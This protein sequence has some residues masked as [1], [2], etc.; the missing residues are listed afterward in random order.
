MASQLTGRSAWPLSEDIAGRFASAGW[1]VLAC[2]GHDGAAVSDV[3]A[4]AKTE[5]G[6]PSLI[7]CKT[8]IGYGSPNRAGTAKAHGAPMGA[9]ENAL[10]RAQL[11]WDHAA[12]E[13]PEQMLASW[14]SVGKQGQQQAVIGR[15]DWLPP[16]TGRN[17]PPP[18]KVMS[19]KQPEGQ[20]ARIKKHW[21]L[22][23]QNWPAGWPASRR[24]RRC[25]LWFPAC[26]VARLI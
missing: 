20:S 10:T 17:S 24:L 22:N 14:R 19:A 18:C 16:R 9:E 7:C 2:D 3:I 25:C 12:F 5:T 23:R 13:I 8:Q 11:G 21:R 4:K 26:L 15:Q 1:Q 6:K